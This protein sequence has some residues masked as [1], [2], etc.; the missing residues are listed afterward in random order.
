[1]CDV[2]ATQIYFCKTLNSSRS[3]IISLHGWAH[4]RIEFLLVENAKSIPEANPPI[5]LT[6]GTSRSTYQPSQTCSQHMYKWQVG[7]SSNMH[8]ITWDRMREFM[9]EFLY[10]VD[11]IISPIFHELWRSEVKCTHVI[12][13]CK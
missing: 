4:S 7:S 5:N 12:K 1:M 3:R 13:L 10:D 6:H 11:N 2:V 9:Y 8:K